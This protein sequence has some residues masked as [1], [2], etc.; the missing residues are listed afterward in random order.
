MKRPII[1]ILLAALS[2]LWLASAG[3]ALAGDR[4]AGEILNELNGIK[5]PAVDPSRPDDA[6]DNREF[7]SRSEEAMKKRA[8]LI[9][10]LFKTDS[11]HEKVPSLMP[12]R[13]ENPIALGE[14]SD[15]KEEVRRVLATTN[16]PR[17]KRDA[18][19]VQVRLALYAPARPGVLPISEIDEYIQLERELEVEPKDQRGGFL[20]ELASQEAK[21][22]KMRTEL[23]NRI[24]KE[25]PASPNADRVRALRRRQAAIG[26]PFS[27]EFTDAIKETHVSIKALRGKV[28]VIDF[29]ASWCA[30]CVD[31]IT[32]L[33]KLYAK[34]RGLGVEFIGVSLDYPAGQGGLDAL[35]KC[36]SDQGIFWPQYYQGSVYDGAFSKSCGVFAVPTVFVI[37]PAGNVYSTEARGKLDSVI[38]ELIEA[39]EA[40]KFDDSIRARKSRTRRNRK[41]N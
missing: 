22:D 24:L 31:E 28:V 36:V 32:S 5:S 26:K 17:L 18:A 23:E 25:F 2:S 3:H 1:V 38:P 10:E 33:K 4:S 7:R 20:L 39:R 8:A 21:D 19:F 35:K 29:W 30:P 12:Q 9:L 11:H 37:D 27:L 14:F 40:G 13:W 15:L 6:A 41:A 16:N 34:Y